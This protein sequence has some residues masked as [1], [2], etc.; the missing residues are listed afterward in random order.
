MQNIPTM[1]PSLLP[2]LFD[3]QKIMLTAQAEISRKKTKDIH[4]N[5]EI[6]IKIKQARFK[7]A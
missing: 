3:T 5:I 2:V 6:N 1:T 7:T 4:K